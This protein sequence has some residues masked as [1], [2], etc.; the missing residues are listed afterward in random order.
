MKLIYIVNARIPTEK[1]HG[2]QIMKMCEAFALNGVELT[3]AVPQRIGV[4][5]KDPFLHY[6]IR[7]KFPIVYLPIV[8]TY[9]WGYLGF[10]FGSVSFAVTSFFYGIFWR[11]KNKGRVVFYSRDQDQFSF[12]SFF[13]GLRPYFFEIHGLKKNNSLHNWLFKNIRGVVATNSFIEK[14]LIE[15]F[16]ILE[17]KTLLQPNGVDL[18]DFAPVINQSDARKSLDIPLD[19]NQKIVVYV[20]HFYKWKGVDTLVKAAEFLDPNIQIYLVGGNDEE[21]TRLKSSIPAG[22]KKVHFVGYQPYS[23][24]PLW[25]SASDVLVITGTAKDADS[26]NYTSPIKLF[27]YMASHKPIIAIDSPAIKDIINDE[28]AFFY[29]PDDHHDLAKV[30]K[31]IVHSQMTQMHIIKRKTQNSYYKS[32]GYSWDSRAVRIIDFIKKK[33]QQ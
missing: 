12:L 33:L 25:N 26:V 22:S 13:F 23:K 7:E 31:S 29:K 10:I 6:S 21:I 14:K 1:A 27:E 8:D 16:P 5:K 4:K 15:S 9:G 17:G 24:I 11:I 18:S 3:L 20:G 32:Q 28:D 19:Q 30:I 2:V